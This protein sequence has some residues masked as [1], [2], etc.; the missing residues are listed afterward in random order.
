MPERLGNAAFA[1]LRVVAGVMFASHG[2]EKLF[3]MFGSPAMTGKPLMLVAGTIELVCGLL[4]ALGLLARPAAVLASG[5]M[6][7][8]YFMAH[9]PHGF[10]PVVNNGEA[11]V[12]YCFLFL[13][14]A[15]RGAGAWSLDATRRRRSTLAGRVGF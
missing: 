8:A 15:A 9:A 12:L 5:E 14:V 7:A 10:W 6:A 11:A 1:L 13:F 2:A 3:G 4:I